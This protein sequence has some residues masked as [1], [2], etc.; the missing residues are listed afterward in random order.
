MEI[1]LM[2]Q[3]LTENI[4]NLINKIFSNGEPQLSMVQIG[5]R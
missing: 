4:V 1:G 3:E 2:F 5:A